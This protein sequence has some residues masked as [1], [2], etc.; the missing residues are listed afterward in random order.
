MR[1]FTAIVPVVALSLTSLRPELAGAEHIP[2]G[3]RLEQRDYEVIKRRDGVTVYKHRTASEIRLAAETQLPASPDQ[4]MAALL[5]YPGQVGHIKRLA[6]SRVLA[7]GRN[8]VRVYQRLSLPVI[9]DRDFTLQVTWGRDREVRFI[10]YHT[11][12]AGPPP[13]SHVVRVSLHEGTWLLR[14]LDGGR[15]TLVRFT[16]RMDMAGSVPRW[17]V[18]GGSA[19]ELPSLFQSVRGLLARSSERSIAWVPS[20]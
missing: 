4:V 17:M 3:V 20:K 11:V 19:K 12:A 7:R 9:D 5:D 14:A 1:F 8:W 2:F 18:R 13:R 16:V 15:S 10:D 6:E